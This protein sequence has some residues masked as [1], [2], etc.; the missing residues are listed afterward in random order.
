MHV[1]P[2]DP[3]SRPNTCVESILSTEPSPQPSSGK[4]EPVSQTHNLDFIYTY[5]YMNYFI[6][7]YIH[8][9]VYVWNRNTYIYMLL[10]K[11]FYMQTHTYACT[12]I[13]AFEYKHCAHMQAHSLST[14]KHAYPMYS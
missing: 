6:Y 11:I 1:S 12:G 4:Y 10:L 3:N 5:I 7:I 14:Q 2:G 9:C 8:I 13:N